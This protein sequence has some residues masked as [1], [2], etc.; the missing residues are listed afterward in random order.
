MTQSLRH[1]VAVQTPLLLFAASFPL[2]CANTDHATS[3]RSKT[4]KGK[5]GMCREKDHSNFIKK[6]QAE[7]KSKRAAEAL[8]ARKEE[9]SEIN[10]AVQKLKKELDSEHAADDMTEKTSPTV[11]RH[12]PTSPQH[13]PPIKVENDETPYSY[14]KLIES[15]REAGKITKRQR[16]GEA[17]IGDWI[18]VKWCAANST[19]ADA[20]ANVVDSAVSDVDSDSNS[21]SKSGEFTSG[22]VLEYRQ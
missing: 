9:K 5:C 22:K 21:K 7:L 2:L 11:K 14:E 10:L 18:P 15:A 12:R 17:G 16:K 8:Q 4:V 19:D 20:D 6:K 3:P 13:D 1:L